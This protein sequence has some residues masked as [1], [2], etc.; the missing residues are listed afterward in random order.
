MVVVFNDGED[1]YFYIDV[2]NLLKMEFSV[3]LKYFM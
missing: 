3:F 1:F 2:L